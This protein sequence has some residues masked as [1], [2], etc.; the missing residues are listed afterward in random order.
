MEEEARP[1]SLPRPA[2]RRLVA[3]RRL[4]DAARTPIDFQIL[5]RVLLHAAL[6]GAAAGLMGSLFFA[7]VEAVQRIALEGWT[8][9]VPL[10]AGGERL[11]GEMTRTPP[12]RPWLLLVVPAIGALAAGAISMWLAPETRGG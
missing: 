9:Y 6:V 11:L 10:R 5:G 3:L 4:L 7:G 2:L 8:G 12:F 1:S